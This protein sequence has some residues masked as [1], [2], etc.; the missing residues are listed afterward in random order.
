MEVVGKPS[1]QVVSFLN[2]TSANDGT[3]RAAA[4]AMPNAVPFANLWIIAWDMTPTFTGSGDSSIV[5]LVRT[6]IVSASLSFDIGNFGLYDFE[7]FGGA[8]S[9]TGTLSTGVTYHCELRYD[10]AGTLTF[11]LNDVLKAT[12]STSPGPDIPDTFDLRLNN[13]GYDNVIHDVY[14]GDGS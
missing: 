12:G 8:I 7:G 5:I 1:L 10:G 4:K 11:W 9:A 2:V 13:D 3:Q 14:Y 6:G